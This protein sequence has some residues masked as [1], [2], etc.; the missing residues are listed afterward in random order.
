MIIINQRLYENTIPDVTNLILIQNFGG[1]CF[2]KQSF[3]LFD[4]RW[5]IASSKPMFKLPCSDE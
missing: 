3:T 2:I 1:I 4:G 5:A